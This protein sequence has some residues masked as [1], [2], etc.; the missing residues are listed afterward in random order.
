MPSR[1]TLPSRLLARLRPHTR[2]LALALLSSLMVACKPPARRAFADLQYPEPVS[3][4]R[5]VRV[6]EISVAYAE[7]G[8]GDTTLVLIHGLG[9]YLPVWTHNLEALAQR[10]RVVAIDLPGYGKSSKSND[11]AYSMEFFARTVQGV[12]DELEIEHPVLVGHSMGGQIALTHALLYPG[13]ARALVLTSPAGLETFEDGEAK[14][15]ADAVTEDFTCKATPEAI[16]ARHTQNFHRMPKDAHFMVSDRVEVIGGPDFPQ[17]CTA[18][19]RSV[20]AMLDEPVADRLGTLQLP[21]LVLFGKYD[22]LIPNPFLHGGS[23]ER[24][25]KTTVK[26]IPGAELVMLPRAGHMAQFEQAEAWNGAV[27][28]FLATLPPPPVRPAEDDEAGNR[29]HAGDEAADD[30][31][32]ATDEDHGGGESDAGE[33]APEPPA[34]PAEPAEPADAVAP[35][36][37]PTPDEAATE[38]GSEPAPDELAPPPSADPDDEATLR[39]RRP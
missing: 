8:Q 18:V 26:A 27:L 6:G 37:T 20:R 9:S 22:Q 29:A 23:T 2:V 38:F 5:T 21:V 31:G 36:P 39:D 15:L 28:G 33:T 10:Y 1:Y 13:R 4:T 12:V 25:A 17:Y 32:P 16:H 24:L 11:Y 34:E 14:W 35:A 19:S 30:G 3:Q 7:L